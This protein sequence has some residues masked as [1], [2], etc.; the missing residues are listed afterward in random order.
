MGKRGGGEP[1]GKD[2]KSSPPIVAAVT[3]M[4]ELEELGVPTGRVA[5]TSLE[6]AG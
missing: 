6:R 2:F 4:P 1:T 3:G 5:Q